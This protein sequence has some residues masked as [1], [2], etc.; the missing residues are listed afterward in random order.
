MLSRHGFMHSVLFFL[1]RTCGRIV[2]K[3]KAKKKITY[4]GE[5]ILDSNGNIINRITRVA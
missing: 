2:A 3:I 4:F 1:P 5:L